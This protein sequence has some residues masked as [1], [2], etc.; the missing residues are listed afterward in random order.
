MTEATCI[1]HSP[2]ETRTLGRRLGALLDS[3]DVVVLA[4]NL[5]A[6]K[7]CLAQGIC[8]GLGV[9]EPVSSPTFTLINEYRG[10]LKVY[11]LDAYRLSGPADAAD[12]GLEEILGGDG[13]ALVEWA[14]RIADYLPQ[15]RLQVELQPDA[16]LGPDVRRL[17]I[18]GSG[19]RGGMLAKELAGQCAS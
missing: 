17:W 16:E 4:G 8:Q 6:G 10:R 1:S 15:D 19:P 14:E 9:D 5:G 3:G 7:T 2:E 18:S 11:H 12:L 13:V